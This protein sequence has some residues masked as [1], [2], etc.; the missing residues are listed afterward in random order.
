MDIRVINK[1]NEIINVS[2]LSIKTS[3][4]WLIGIDSGNNIVQIEE[5]GSEEEAENRLEAFGYAI[6]EGNRQKLES[7]VIRT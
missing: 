6:E 4:K 3:G 5:Y 7:I 1:A 2:S